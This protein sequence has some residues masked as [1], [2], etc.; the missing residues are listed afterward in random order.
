MTKPTVFLIEE[1]DDTRPALR[2]N[3]KD[4]NYNVTIAI[5][6]EDA[7]NRVADGTLKA[8]VVLINLNDKPPEEILEIGRNIRQ[9]GGLKAPIVVIA[10]EYGEDLEGKDISAGENDYISY[11]GD[12]EQLF[13][14]L[15]RLTPPAA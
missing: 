4:Y 13:N 10:Q 7:L 9:S 14:L 12:G 15:S 8:D 1:N 6:E 2:Q 3:L 5:D 11:L